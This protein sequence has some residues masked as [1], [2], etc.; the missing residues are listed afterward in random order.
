MVHALE[1]SLRVLT[2]S[3]WLVDLRPSGSDRL[4]MVIRDGKE[5]D[6]GEI[7]TSAGNPDVEASDAAVGLM[8]ARGAMRETGKTGF[9]YTY[10]W[11]TPAEMRNYIETEWSDFSRLPP[12]TWHR[13]LALFRDGTRGG[14]HVR[15]RSQ[16]H[17][18]IY[19]KVPAGKRLSGEYR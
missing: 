3:G 12:T 11:D 10:D 14:R 16:M 9:S 6:A 13:A 19:Q 7:D 5:V 1:D 4:L 2:P 8:V 15:I 17:L 18:A